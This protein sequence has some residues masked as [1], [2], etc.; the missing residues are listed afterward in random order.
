MADIQQDIQNEGGSSVA[1]RMQQ[2]SPSGIQNQAQQAKRQNAVSNRINDQQQ[3]INNFHQL[4]AQRNGWLD[5]W[6]SR[7]MRHD[8]YSQRA[9]HNRWSAYRQYLNSFDASSTKELRQT[10]EQKIDQLAQRIKRMEENKQESFKKRHEQKMEAAKQSE[11]FQQKFGNQSQNQSQSQSQDQS[12]SQSQNQSQ[13]QSQNQSQSQSQN[14][15]PSQS[16]N[17]SQ[18]QS[19]GQAPSVFPSSP[20]ATPPSEPRSAAQSK[21]RRVDAAAYSF[22][23]SV[24]DIVHLNLQRSNSGATNL[25]F[26][27]VAAVDSTSSSSMSESR[28]LSEMNSSFSELKM[29][30]AESSSLSSSLDQMKG[31]V[32]KML[33]CSQA[34]RTDFQALATVNEELYKVK[35]TFGF[36]ETN[37]IS[38][39]WSSDF[40]MRM[41]AVM[42]RTMMSSTQVSLTSQSIQRRFFDVKSR[43]ASYKAASSWSIMRSEELIREASIS[44]RIDMESIKSIVKIGMK[45]KDGPVED[46][47]WVSSAESTMAFTSESKQFWSSSSYEDVE[48]RRYR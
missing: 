30:A 29:E 24:L 3:T 38:S 18:S 10:A 26:G 35:E 16:Q 42:K 5:N 1:S 12:Q 8:E 21:S 45:M 34:G 37:Q 13:S 19:S 33:A 23:S 40:L 14:Q 41:D 48:Q 11:A 36:S 28:S 9:E 39:Q 7:F 17:P 15:T 32:D 46:M 43:S 27:G 44:S 25:N 22:M 47:A 2:F 20:A 4:Q 31:L 6:D